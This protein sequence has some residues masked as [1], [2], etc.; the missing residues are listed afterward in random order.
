MLLAVP[1]S[2]VALA[3]AG[4]LAAGE[5]EPPTDPFAGA[6]QLDRAALVAEVLARNP[7]LEAARR[8]LEAARQRPAQA[9]AI[10]GPMI[11]Y[12]FA[13]GS[14]GASHVP[15]GQEIELSQPLPYPGKRRL[16]AAA[17]G[18]DADVAAADLQALT[19][20]LERRAAE[21]HADD[22][23]VYR[24][25]AINAE[26]RALLEDFKDVATARYAAGLA[27]QQD[28]LTAEAELA[29][30]QHDG[31]MLRSE[32]AVVAAQ[33]N[34]L[35]HRPSDAPLPPPPTELPMPAGSADA[36]VAELSERA[37][38]QRPEVQ[39]AD[40]TIRARQA[41]IDLAKLGRRPEF[42]VSTGYNSMWSDTEHRWMIGASMQLPLGR[43]RIGAGVA[44]AESRLAAAQAEREALSDEVR[45]EVAEAATLWHEAHHVL[46][47]YPSRLLPV[48]RDRVEA[49]LAGFRSGKNDFLALVEAE[50]GLRDVTLQYHQALAEIERRRARLDAAL[51]V[52]RLSGAAQPPEPQGETR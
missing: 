2:L 46:D 21:L 14:I 18:A 12:G 8:A 23:V 9:A 35:L 4:G 16:R 20:E 39:G 26:H 11:A 30:L 43:A 28:P 17:A 34:A 45:R 15:F 36:D 1:V 10:E 24:A 48:A 31:L 7:G 25:E 33:I 44:E 29:H 52:G 40:A 13:P 27:S 38:T 32:R 22:Y 49:A 19:I 37:L 50:R 47:L 3:C 51:G 6:S 42:A 41:E 5:L